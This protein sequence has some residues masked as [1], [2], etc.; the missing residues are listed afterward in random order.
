MTK[1]VP[2]TAEDLEH[3]AAD[4]VVDHYHREVLRWAAT[5]IHALEADLIRLKTDSSNHVAAD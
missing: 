1:G 3:A 2:F 4:S 5:R